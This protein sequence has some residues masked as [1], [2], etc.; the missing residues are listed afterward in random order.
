[1]TD[2]TWNYPRCLVVE[3][4]DGDTLS[5]DM[6]LGQ[7]IWI[8]DRPVRLTGMACR[9]LSEPGG[10]EA[11]DFVRGLLPVGSEVWV[12]STGWDKY[13]GRIDGWVRL[14]H[15]GLYTTVQN[16]LI[17]AG[18]GVYWSGRGR[19]PKPPWP[20]PITRSGRLQ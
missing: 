16:L 6:D 18:Y 12:E 7:D 5:V 8:K 2:I 4:H 15:E 13:G 20:I 19:Q 9:E 1:M 17:E 10:V 14:V 3:V 11:R